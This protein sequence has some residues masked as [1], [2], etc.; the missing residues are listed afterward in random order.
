MDPPPLPTPPQPDQSLP[1]STTDASVANG[2]Q[3]PT[4][5]NTMAPI[6]TADEMLIMGRQQMQIPTMPAVPAAQA[7]T[8]GEVSMTSVTSSQNVRLI[9]RHRRDCPLRSTNSLVGS[10][11]AGKVRDQMKAVAWLEYT[12]RA[13]SGYVWRMYSSSR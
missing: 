7:I 9:M 3:V 5:G 12:D 6:P 4:N 8:A 1:P 13:K 2:F 10:R 11:G